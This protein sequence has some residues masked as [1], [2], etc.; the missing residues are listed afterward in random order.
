MKKHLGSTLAIIIG[1]LTFAAG[2]TRPGALLVAGPIIIVGAL[3]YRSAK[4]RNLREA[5]NS[6]LRRSLEAIAVI[7]IIAAVL[8][9]KNVAEQIITDPIPN[10]LIPLWAVVAYAAVAFRKPRQ[11]SNEA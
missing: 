9:Q 1:V 4:K 6:T 10:L 11:A 2:T 7:S 8:L 3:A 5:V